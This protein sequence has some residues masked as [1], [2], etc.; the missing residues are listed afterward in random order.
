MMIRRMIDTTQ[1]IHVLRREGH[2]GRALG[3]WIAALPP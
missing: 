2:H 1:D 3:T